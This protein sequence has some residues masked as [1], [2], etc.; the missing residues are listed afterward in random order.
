[1][2]L[3][4]HR[5]CLPAAII[6]ILAPTGT[7]STACR[8]RGNGGSPGHDISG[9]KRIPRTIIERRTLDNK[10]THD[11]CARQINYPT[12]TYRELIIYDDLE[13]L[14]EFGSEEP[15]KCMNCVL[16]I[17]IPRGHIRR[18]RRVRNERNQL[19]NNVVRI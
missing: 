12:T 15:E 11:L 14:F 2:C 1:M 19:L 18:R 5:A 4:P 8:P 3:R 7:D 17:Y 16:F 10:L 9:Q 6:G 13:E